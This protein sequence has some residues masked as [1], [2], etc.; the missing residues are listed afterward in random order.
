[1][2]SILIHAPKI[3]DMN[4]KREF[5]KQMTDLLEKTYKL[6]RQSYYIY[7]KEDPPENVGIGGQLVSD[8]EK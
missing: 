4:I 5:I 8:R 1:M 6:P 3:I 2:P 7:L